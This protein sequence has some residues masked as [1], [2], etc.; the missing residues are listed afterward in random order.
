M[1][2]KYQLSKI[3]PDKLYLK[4]KYRRIMHKKLNLQDPKTFNEKL[5][6]LKLYNRKPEYTTM[7]DKYAVKK[8]VASRIGDE[9]IIPTIGVWNSFDEID[10]DKL[11]KQFVLKCTHDS[12]GLV[13][14]KD[15]NNLNLEVARRKIE[16][17]LANNYYYTGREW[18]Y[19]NVKPRII[20]E[21]Y[22]S[23]DGDE[24]ELTDYKVLC[25]NGIP[26]L[27]QIHKGR[28]SGNH[29]QDI[30]DTD[31]NKTEFEQP[32]DPRSDE[33]MEKP[34]FADKMLSLS[35]ILAK[36][37]PHVR[38]DWYYTRGSLL[39]GEITFFDGS[40]FY[41]F[42]DNQDEILGSWITLPIK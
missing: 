4:I 36:D 25:F 20:A 31:W 12:G 8:Y 33:V 13:I 39:F 3:L 5:Q 24:N 30:Y 23:N 1:G 40:G 14:C 15:K 11:P 38:I 28:F 10:F 2:L 18:P 37:I 42:I 21:E 34:V 29:T 16:R 6:W 7:V 27:I 22:L 19:K 41:P 26:K 35:K 9:F 17:S 32:D